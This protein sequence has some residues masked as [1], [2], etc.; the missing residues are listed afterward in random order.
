MSR[1][2]KLKICHIRCGCT[3][4]SGLLNVNCDTLPLIQAFT[5]SLFSVSFESHVCTDFYNTKCPCGRVPPLPAAPEQ[6]Q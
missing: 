1:Y 3:C 2:N 4:K 5:G 6:H